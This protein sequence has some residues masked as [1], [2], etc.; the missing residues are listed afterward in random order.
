MIDFNNPVCGHL[1][2]AKCCEITLIRSS[3]WNPW[4]NQIRPKV[5]EYVLDHD[6]NK[7]PIHGYSIKEETLIT[8]LQMPVGISK[9]AFLCKSMFELIRKCGHTSVT[10][11][12]N[13]FWKT[14]SPCEDIITIECDKLRSF[15]Y[16]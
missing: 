1:N 13:V 6:E 14:Y 16:S 3:Q 4:L 5:I 11:C 15:A 2:K 8:K 9:E 12:S 7:N 10:T